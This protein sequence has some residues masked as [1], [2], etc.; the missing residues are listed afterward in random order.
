MILNGKK[1]GRAF[2]LM[3]YFCYQREEDTLDR[4]AFKVATIK[5]TVMF[6]VTCHS[7]RALVSMSQCPL[8]RKTAT[9]DL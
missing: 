6:T 9:A 1:G 7:T 5:L 4:D 3:V 8:S 2:L